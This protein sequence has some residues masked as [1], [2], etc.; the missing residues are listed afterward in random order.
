MPG[1]LLSLS[2]YVLKKTLT[3]PDL[4]VIEDGNFRNLHKCEVPT[5]L[6]KV[7]LQGQPGSHLLTRSSAQKIRAQGAV[8]LR[9]NREASNRE[10][11][12]VPISLAYRRDDIPRRFV[13]S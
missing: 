3:S 13:I 9:A 4:T 5:A 12:R 10:A 8:N 2:A 1:F 6:S 7:R 11:L